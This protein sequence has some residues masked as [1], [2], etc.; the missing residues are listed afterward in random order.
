MLIELKHGCT[1][2]IYAPSDPSAFAIYFHGG[3]LVYGSKSDIPLKLVT[4]LNNHNISVIALDYPLAPNHSLNEIINTTLEN[5]YELKNQIIAD[6]PY[7]MIGRS[8]GSFLMFQLINKLIQQKEQLPNKIINFYGF[9]NLDDLIHSQIN[10]TQ[11]LHIDISQYN[12]TDPMTDDPQMSRYLL[13]LYGRQNNQIKSFFKVNTYEEFIIPSE[14]LSKFPPSFNT[15]STS[16]EE[17]PFKCSKN[18][19]KIIPNSVFYPVYYFEH[20]F[21]KCIDKEEIISIL[22]KLNEWL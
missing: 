15:A 21:L 10:H 2:K 8:A 19:S 4:M 22:D 9:Y 5:Y 18:L 16:D 12:I 7:M 11:S 17:V 1:A 3:G 20:D 13:Y 14:I 6:M